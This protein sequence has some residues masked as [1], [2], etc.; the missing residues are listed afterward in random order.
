MK[1]FTLLSL[2]AC[3]VFLS[4]CAAPTNNRDGSASAPAGSSS[5]EIKPGMTKAEVLALWGEPSE[6]KTTAS[7]ET[8]RWA[9]Q[10]WKRHVPVY[11]TWAHVEEH[12]V[13]FGAD[14]RVVGAG[15]EDYGNAFQ[16]GWRRAYGTN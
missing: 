14:G 16:E 3:T 15:N 10:G 6:K 2:A 11:G 7:G 9:D 4:Q 12:V 8:W 13:R 5:G 1:K